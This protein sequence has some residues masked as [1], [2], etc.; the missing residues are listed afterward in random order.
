MNSVIGLLWFAI[1]VGIAVIGLLVWLLFLKIPG[2]L[3]A[4][5][6]ALGLPPGAP[7]ADRIEPLRNAITDIRNALGAPAAPN[8]LAGVVSAI[9]TTVGQ[10]QNAVGTPQ[11]GTTVVQSLG[12]PAQAVQVTQ[13]L[14]QLQTSLNQALQ[15]IALMKSASDTVLAQAWNRLSPGMPPPFAPQITSISAP[16]GQHVTIEGRNFSADCRVWFGVRD[17]QP[18]GGATANHLRVRVP[19]GQSGSVDVCVQSANGLTSAPR[20]FTYPD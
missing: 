14:T 16:H 10:I 15:E 3:V 18:E 19:E 5:Q 20:S 8:T 2:K 12:Q 13:A 7:V 17:C 11:G 1:V 6:T 9:Q 4:I